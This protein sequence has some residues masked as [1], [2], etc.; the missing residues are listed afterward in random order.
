MITE[1]SPITDIAVEAKDTSDDVRQVAMAIEASCKHIDNTVTSM[2]LSD[3][4]QFIDDFP[5]PGIEITPDMV[6]Y[7]VDTK[8]N[9]YDITYIFEKQ[10]Y[11]GTG[12]EL[13]YDMQ[14]KFPT[15]ISNAEMF[16]DENIVQRNN[17]VLYFSNPSGEQIGY[18]VEPDSPKSYMYHGSFYGKTDLY[19]TGIQKTSSDSNYNINAYDSSGALVNNIAIK[20]TYYSY[21]SFAFDGEYFYI[22]TNHSTSG[23]R[24]I[25]RH[26]VNGDYI[27]S[28]SLGTSS[29]H[30]RVNCTENYIICFLYSLN[31][32]PMRIHKDF[33]S[34][35]TI[36]I[37]S[38]TNV[39]VSET[40]PLYGLDS[41]VIRCG[42]HVAL[43]DLSQK[44]STLVGL[45]ANTF[46]SYFGSYCLYY[47]PVNG[48]QYIDYTG[49]IFQLNPKALAKTFVGITSNGKKIACRYNLEKYVYTNNA[50][51]KKACFAQKRG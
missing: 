32:P 14:S 4:P 49:K 17:N 8:N 18:I 38:T 10:V 44:T 40:F 20:S 12:D 36:I 50:T 19:F 23:E 26:K 11:E 29:G 27:D 43:Y 30:T 39:D 5:T 15:N 42:N 45:V 33:S 1:T 41:I 16:S 47:T 7:G 35:S 22:L 51:I 21:H 48:L 37:P 31:L 2:K 13:T 25:D 46:C 28:Y 34:S 3:V 24:F 6:G 9:E